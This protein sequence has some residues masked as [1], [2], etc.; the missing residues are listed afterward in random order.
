MARSFSVAKVLCLLAALSL[1]GAVS[2]QR[3]DYL[4]E[5]KTG[6]LKSVRLSLSVGSSSQTKMVA[7][8]GHFSELGDSPSFRGLEDMKM[9]AFNGDPSLEPPDKGSKNALNLPISVPA[10]N[11]LNYPKVSA[12]F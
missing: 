10:F 3:K 8:D 6:V 4:P 11:A 5:D 9:V 1:A 12:Y 7:G 2:C